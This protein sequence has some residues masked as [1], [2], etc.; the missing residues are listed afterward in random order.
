MK[1]LLP[2]ALISLLLTGCGS[3]FTGAD[4]TISYEKKNA[5]GSYTKASY[6]SPKEQKGSIIINPETGEVQAEISSTQNADL[7]A[8][9]AQVMGEANKSIAEAA[10]AIVEKLP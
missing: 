3:V 4:T 2:L 7:A 10:K 9:A 1:K 8:S 6:K 5:D